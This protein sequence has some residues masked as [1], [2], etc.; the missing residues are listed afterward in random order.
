MFHGLTLEECGK[1][2]GVTRERSRQVEAKFIKTIKSRLS[3]DQ[4][5]IIG[6]YLKNNPPIK[7]MYDLELADP[8]FRDISRY[9]LPATKANVFFSHFFTKTNLARWEYVDYQYKIFNNDASSCE[10]IILT[11]NLNSE[12]HFKLSLKDSVKA[13]C[14]IARREDVYDYVYKAI[15]KKFMNSGESVIGRYGLARLRFKLPGSPIHVDS[16]KDVIKKEFDFNMQGEDRVIA[17]AFIGRDE[18]SERTFIEGL[19]S[20]GKLSFIFIHDV[21]DEAAATLIVKHSIKILSENPGRQMNLRNTLNKILAI[22]SVNKLIKDR[23][24][25]MT[26]DLLTVIMRK[27]AHQIDS[28]IRDHGRLIW[29]ISEIDAQTSSKRI[30]IYPLILKILKENGAPMALQDI[31]K[32]ASKVRGF[33]HFQ[34]H[35]TQTTPNVTL[36]ARGL[37][38]LRHR[39]INVTKVQENQLIAAILQS[40][41]QEKKIL[42]IYDMLKFKESFDIEPSVKCFQIAKMLLAH[43]PV[44]RRRTPDQV[45]F[46]QKCS[47]KDLN[48]FV[49]YS[50]D[51]TDKEIDEY[52]SKLSLEEMPIDEI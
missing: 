7:N 32:E 4:T 19:Y 15:H 45:I 31:K 28:R 21:I 17:A 1:I 47:H 38:G 11:Y 30:E 23:S 48:K 39:D 8:L 29:S 9:L 26:V 44:G 43:I 24:V 50:I 13:E 20:Y 5:N 37:W 33:S 18:T 51:V 22:D 42:D 35:T 25:N 36:I 34:I 6:I 46:L 2:V 16:V 40:F 52:I 14:L 10:E 41:N 12:V 49:I 27:Y 3:Y